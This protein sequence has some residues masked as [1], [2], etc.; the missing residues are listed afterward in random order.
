[1]E[2]MSPPSLCEDEVTL[3]LLYL[4]TAVLW[5][6]IVDYVTRATKNSCI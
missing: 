4:S 5:V 2:E 1:M 3:N 6:V